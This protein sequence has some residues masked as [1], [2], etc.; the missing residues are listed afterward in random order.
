MTCVSK[1]EIPKS[2]N[3]SK[4]NYFNKKKIGNIHFKTLADLRLSFLSSKTQE[5][6]RYNLSR[7]QYKHF[8]NL[9]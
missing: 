2:H 6:I 5:K 4:F 8:V 3:I 1:A 7:I 9:A